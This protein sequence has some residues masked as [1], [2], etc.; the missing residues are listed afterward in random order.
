MPR[1][2]FRQ[3][4]FSCGLL[5]FFSVLS[6]NAA[7]A[8]DE[9]IASTPGDGS[10]VAT[11]KALTLEFSDSL[12]ATGYRIQV[13]GP[14]G[15]IPGSPSISGT[16]LREDFP[17]NLPAGNYRVNWRVVSE[18]GHPISGKFAFTVDEVRPAPNPPSSPQPVSE[19]PAAGP[20]ILAQAP[21]KA[22]P[23]RPNRRSIAPW[24]GAT[25][26]LGGV[27]VLGILSWRRRRRPA[28]ELP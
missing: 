28:G 14:S 17:G 26:G 21:G 4:V 3:A 12:I 22:T 9:L 13:T 18:D 7:F 25:A 8:H 6:S 11:A 1:L 19:S 15:A 2:S 23:E 27:G 24:L 10:T 5:L 16:V 20:S